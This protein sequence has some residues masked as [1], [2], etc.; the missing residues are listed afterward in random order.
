MA[1]PLN[2]NPFMANA[3]AQQVQRGL[4]GS[5]WGKFTGV[6]YTGLPV[7]G[8]VFGRGA[9]KIATKT[10]SGFWAKAAQLFSLDRTVQETTIGDVGDAISSVGKKVGSKVG[11][12]VGNIVPE[13]ETVGA[14]VS[15]KFGDVIGNSPINSETVNQTVQ[16]AGGLFTRAFNGLGL[17]R[18][19]NM[20][21]E[22]SLKGAALQRDNLQRT[23]LGM[24]SMLSDSSTISSEHA[25]KLR[26]QLANIIEM[27]ESPENAKAVAGAMKE[28]SKNVSEWYKV[29]PGK[30]ANDL[31]RTATA[32]VNFSLNVVNKVTKGT[33]ANFGEY[34]KSIPGRWKNISLSQ[35]TTTGVNLAYTG[36]QVAGHISS[37]KQNLATL[38]EVYEQMGGA[39]VSDRVL[40]TGKNMPE[41]IKTMRV[42]MRGTLGNLG[43]NLA[44]LAGSQALVMRSGGGSGMMV[45][46]AANAIG[47][48]LANWLIP[49]SEVLN[50]AAEINATLKAGQPVSAETYVDLL[51]AVNKGVSKDGRYGETKM[52]ADY[53][54]VYAETHQL[55]A[56][57]LLKLANE[58]GKDA[59]LN[60]KITAE[61][62][63]LVVQ[64]KREAE[65]AA[66]EEQ[67]LNPLAKAGHVKKLEAERD[68]VREMHPQGQQQYRA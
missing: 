10:G 32:G 12:K 26:G 44:A 56:G 50:T 21:Q 7:V 28:F 49:K 46:M 30:I 52:R 35:A 33:A 24:Q 68:N 41:E 25:A 47:S 14:T 67:E 42:S 3:G 59:S 66:F 22:G 38:R 60:Q 1:P 36:T 18:V 17:N 54:A 63:A 31:H 4:L 23:L 16:Q 2:K 11:I 6:M 8:L 19:F 5:M 29:E 55:N 43:V 13:M 34:L 37:G 40:L 45:A 65:R 9:N 15:S 20:Y 64:R 62:D 57:A 61:V 51:G 58:T 48:S 53:L 27:N 39:T